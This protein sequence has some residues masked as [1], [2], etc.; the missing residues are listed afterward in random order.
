MNKFGKVSV[1]SASMALPVSF[2]VSN[3][4]SWYLKSNNPDNVDITQGLAYLRPILVSGF[5]LFGVLIAIGFV[6]GVM[7]LKKDQDRALGRLGLALAVS[8]LVL[9]SVAAVAANRTDAAIDT[10][11]TQKEQQFFD[12]IKKQ[13]SN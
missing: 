1:V 8:V 9:S 12:A 2:V 3:V 5:V 7:A 11:R 6:A 10:Y 4:I 13:E